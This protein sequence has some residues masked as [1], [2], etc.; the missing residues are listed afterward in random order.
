MLIT[1][2]FSR[3]IGSNLH[4]SIYLKQ[5]VETITE[6]REGEEMDCRVTVCESLGKNRY[7]LETEALVAGSVAIKG[8]AWILQ[9]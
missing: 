1:S 8:H 5:T 6:I 3:V 2:I 7:K 4:K 9:E